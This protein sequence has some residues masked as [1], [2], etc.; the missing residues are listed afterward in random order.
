MRLLNDPQNGGAS[1]FRDDRSHSLEEVRVPA[2]G[3]TQH[4]TQRGFDFMSVSSQNLFS[5]PLSLQEKIKLGRKEGKQYFRVKQEL[6][7]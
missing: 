2:P 7:Q 6:K 3:H 1:H 5:F 4:K